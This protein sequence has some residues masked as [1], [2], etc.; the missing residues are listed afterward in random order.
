MSGQEQH[1]YR[2]KWLEAA[3]HE[4]RHPRRRHTAK[5]DILKQNLC[6]ARVVKMRENPT[7]AESIFKE[8]L[9][10]VCGV[11][12]KFQAGFIKGNAFIIVDFFIPKLKLAI[13]IDGGYHK[14][15]EQN[16]KDEW[17]DAYL[18]S[19]GIRVVRFTNDEA[20]SLPA[21]AIARLAGMPEYTNR[22][23]K[24]GALMLERKPKQTR[25]RDNQE[26]YYAWYWRCP[27][28]KR[29]YMP[30]ECRPSFSVGQAL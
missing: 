14:T 10:A 20:V 25:I 29:N 17:K 16:R 12:F 30:R 19:R 6:S 23:C 3:K 13:E 2:I 4:L 24:C 9:F 28:C 26:F 15:A 27:R 11:P 5:T 22:R 1:K 21:A 8:K 7:Q 18:L